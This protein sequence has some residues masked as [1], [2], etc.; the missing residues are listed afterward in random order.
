MRV[1]CFCANTWGDSPPPR[2]IGPERC[3][4]VNVPAYACFS[5]GIRRAEVSHPARNMKKR[6]SPPRISRTHTPAP[7]F[8]LPAVLWDAYLM[9]THTRSHSA[10]Q[11]RTWEIGEEIMRSTFFVAALAAGT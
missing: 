3:A 7:R 6:E 5:K 9:L 11:Q 4:G 8:R 2:T 1:Q 10:L